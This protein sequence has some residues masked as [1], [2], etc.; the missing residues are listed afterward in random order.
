MRTFV[1]LAALTVA[2]AYGV[3]A[4]QAQSFEPRFSLDG[5][6]LLLASPGPT[7]WDLETGRALQVFS[8]HVDPVRAFALSPD[9]KLVLTGGGRTG[10]LPPRDTS[11]RLW[12]AETG[13]EIRQFTGHPSTVSR[14]QFTPDGTRMMSVGGDVR[15]WNIATGLQL[16]VVP[17]GSG[18][19]AILSPD[20]S[21]ILND[22]G[23]STFRAILDGNT[24]K[25]ICNIESKDGM[26]WSAQFSPDSAFVVTG[27]LGVVQTWDAQTCKAVKPFIGHTN[28]VLQSF[29]SRDGT[30]IV[31]ASADSTA[32][33]WDAQ[34]GRELQRF[35]HPGSLDQLLLNS[36]GSRLL[37]R[38]GYGVNA[39]PGLAHRQCASLWDVD[40]GREIRRFC[41]ENI[42]TM[43][44]QVWGIV[45][46]SP[47]G[48]TI[49]IVGLSGK[50]VY[51]W[52]AVT[53]E[54][55]RSY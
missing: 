11:V 54:L 50:P 53:G 44:W 24:G 48:K 20:G 49:P 7:L 38:W 47:D 27:A 2:M 21:K 40:S 19:F 42:P 30:R 31:T 8:G 33:L 9:G 55:M 10:D 17:G 22:I 45:G 18:G 51:L 3:S 39:P 12:D 29:F 37:T 14:V 4:A 41:D 6:R 1:R 36:N 5:R 32:R 25:P 35:E 34:S 46:F 23:K 52:N 13:K 15:M 28:F 16:F 43:T 26:L